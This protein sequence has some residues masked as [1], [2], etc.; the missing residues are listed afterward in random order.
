MENMMRGVLSLS[1]AK[2]SDITV[3]ELSTVAIINKVSCDL[4]LTLNENA[5]IIV[6]DLPNV[7]G[8]ET[9][10]TQ[11]FLNIIG[12]AVK[13][14]SKHESPKIEID[15]KVDGNHVIY[16]IKDNGIGIP[17]SEQEKMFK[18]FNRMENAKSFQGNGVGLSIVYRIMNRLEGNITYE[19]KENEGTTFILT[20]KKP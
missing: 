16:K 7:M 10:L 13:Y 15:G 1:R 14:S 17:E 20:F 18:I 6:G 8:D 5:E 11:V 2:S 4:K 9:M 19:S 3:Q 12:N